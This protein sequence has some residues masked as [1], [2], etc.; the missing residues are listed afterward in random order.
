MFWAFSYSA[1]GSIE[2]SVIYS[3]GSALEPVSR[4]FGMGWKLFMAF[5]V[6]SLVM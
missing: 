4:F 3:I 6:A 5:H 2:D 1:T